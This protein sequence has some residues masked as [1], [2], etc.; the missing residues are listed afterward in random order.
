MSPT[1]APAAAGTATTEAPVLLDVRGLR[2]DYGQPGDPLLAV[3]DVDLQIRR[4]EVLGI[5][6]ESGS[7]KTTL[8]T[9]LLRLQRPPARTTAGTALLHPRPGQDGPP[10]DLLTA[11][12][13]E[14]RAL[15]WERLSVVFQSAMNALNPVHRLESQFIDTLAA[16]RRMSRADA[17]AH[18]SHL[19]EL[20]GI[21]ASR[22]RSYPHELSGGMRQRATIALAL[23]CE[24]DLVVMDEPTTAVD[25]VMQRQILAQ[26]QRLQAEFGFAIVFITHDFSLL[27]EIADRLAIMYGGR[28]VETGTPAELQGDPRHHYTAGLRDSFPPLRGPLVPLR[29]IPGSPPDLRTAGIA[30]SFADRCAGAQEDC[31]STVPPLFVEGSRA[32]AC[33]HPVGTPAPSS[34]GGRP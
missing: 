14:L 5:A 18:A 7:G 10:V 30:C 21:P 32:H 19:L 16:H 34:P 24:P 15:R 9:A 27:L 33:L 31:R 1:T 8:I 17:R 29:G 25:V 20:V 6:G 3:R 23:A 28:I 22:A 13:R 12:R 11:S 4:G 26:V 2:V